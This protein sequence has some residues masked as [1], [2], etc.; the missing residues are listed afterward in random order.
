[1]LITNLRKDYNDFIFRTK[2]IQHDS[3]VNHE[4]SLPLTRPTS[5]TLRRHSLISLNGERDYGER[6]GWVE[7]GTLTVCE[8]RLSRDHHPKT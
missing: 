8:K 5:I 7:R 1:M 6:D 3:K 2:K 4:P